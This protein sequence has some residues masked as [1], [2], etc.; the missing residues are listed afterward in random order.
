MVLAA[1]TWAAGIVGLKVRPSGLGTV[2]LTGWQMLLGGI[3]IVIATLILD[4][5]P[6]LSRVTWRGVAGTA[7]AAVIGLTFCFA[8]YNKIVLMLPAGVAA[9]SILAIPA[10][11][12]FSSALVLGEPVGPLELVALALVLAAVALVLL[13]RRAA[14]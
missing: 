13:P 9:V 5:H 6:D 2:A 4:P 3:P 12:L 10:V 7:Y 11:G 14:G 8:A 1:L